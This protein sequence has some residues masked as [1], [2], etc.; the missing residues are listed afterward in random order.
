M[1]PLNY[2]LA[3]TLCL[4]FTSPLCLL[5]QQKYERESRIKTEDVPLAAQAF[6]DSLVNHQKIKWYL[7]ESL[8]HFSI[9]AKFKLDEN[10]YSVEFD[11]LGRLEDVELLVKEDAIP[12]SV[13][14]QIR[15]ILDSLFS[16]Y[17]I[18]KSQ[19]QYTGQAEKLLT[20]IR[21][22]E[23]TEGY[24]TKFEL[25][26]KGRTEQGVHLYEMLFDNSGHLLSQSTIVLK[27]ANNL[28]Y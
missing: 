23:A 7:E 8:T 9:E 12:S 21:R 19:I 20:L 10:K 14:D 6:V 26:V 22:G 4:L 28:E 25:I 18:R 3:L 5:G 27:N 15:E 24:T 16:R 1:P 13:Y 11:T 17:R 2:S